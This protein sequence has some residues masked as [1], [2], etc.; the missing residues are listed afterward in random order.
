MKIKMSEFKKGLVGFSDQHDVKIK[1]DDSEIE[2]KNS[3]LSFYEWESVEFKTDEAWKV[4]FI[5]KAS[6]ELEQVLSIFDRE[7][8]DTNRT[9]K[10]TLFEV[11]PVVSA[12]WEKRTVIAV[13]EKIPG[14]NTI[15]YWL[16]IGWDIAQLTKDWQT[17]LDLGGITTYSYWPYTEEQMKK[18]C[19]KLA[20]FCKE[21]ANI[22]GKVTGHDFDYIWDEIQVKS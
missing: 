9:Y 14:E 5:K 22:S 7:G 20:E 19:E 13:K 10:K 6:W 18:A 21:Q 1:T 8:K 11:I 12:G 15:A 4:S 3:E 2:I 17:P 16:R